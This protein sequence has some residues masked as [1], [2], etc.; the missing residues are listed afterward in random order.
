[1][2]LH[3]PSKKEK[4][5]H[6]PLLG[7]QRKYYREILCG[8]IKNSVVNKNAFGSSLSNKLMQLRKCCLHPYLIDWP[9]DEN[10]QVLV[11][12]DLISHSGKIQVLD[13]L[14]VFG[15]TFD[16]LSSIGWCHFS[17]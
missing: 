9:S 6:V 4:L 17:I 7:L 12:E 14:L 2:A 10:Q 11:D 13:K 3:L 16:G 8:T 1:V 5:I 15:I